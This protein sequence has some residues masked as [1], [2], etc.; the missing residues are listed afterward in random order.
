MHVRES[1]EC[2]TAAAG[3]SLIGGAGGTGRPLRALIIE[4]SDD[5]YELLVRG[6]RRCGYELIHERVQTPG[7]MK[8]A[9][10]DAW[11]IVF[12]DWT[13]PSFSAIEALVLYKQCGLDLPFVVLSGTAEREMEEAALMAGAHVFVLKGSLGA[14]SELVEQE[15]EKARLRAAARLDDGA[16]GRGQPEA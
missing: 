7:A 2:A 10:G 12:A 4:D 6:L 1:G 3:P 9:L 14:L 8:K 5:D 13:L 11:D 16:D 15:L